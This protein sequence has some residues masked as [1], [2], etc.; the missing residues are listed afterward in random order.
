MW[1][2]EKR[3][4]EGGRGQLDCTGCPNPGTYI[5]QLSAVT[6]TGGGTMAP[7]HHQGT[8]ATTSL[9]NLLV[10]KTLA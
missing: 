4:R 8:S 1:G 5:K 10:Y 9:T 2:R 6:G 7:R 3:G